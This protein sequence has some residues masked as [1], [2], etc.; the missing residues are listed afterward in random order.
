ML[1]KLYTHV[2]DHNILIKFNSH[3]HP[4]SHLGVMAL[5]LQKTSWKISCLGPFWKSLCPILTKLY[6]HVCDHKILIK[7]D[8]H[9]NRCSHLRVTALYLKKTTWKISCLGPFWK[10]VCPILT[11]LF[12]HVCDH[13]ILIKFDSHVNRFSHLG[14]MALY[15]Q[16]KYWKIS[17]IIMALTFCGKKNPGSWGIRVLWTHF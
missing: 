6:T 3:E 7:S 1:T 4:L 2:C 8:S 15:L 9:V 11:K 10:S 17:L 12:T 14:V 13:N 16:K 5:Y